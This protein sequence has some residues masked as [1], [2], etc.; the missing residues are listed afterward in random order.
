MKK[1]LGTLNSSHEKIVKYCMLPTQ[2]DE[3]KEK[4][5]KN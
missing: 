2:N 5:G 3:D 1:N 4:G